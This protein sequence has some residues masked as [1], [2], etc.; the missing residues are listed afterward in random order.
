MVLEPGIEVRMAW[1][2][3]EILNTG[4][5]PKSGLRESLLGGSPKLPGPGGNWGPGPSAGQRGNV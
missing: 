4:G 1:A 5:G 3:L 2:S